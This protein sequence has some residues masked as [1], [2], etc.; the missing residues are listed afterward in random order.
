[1]R[2]RTA[3]IN[4]RVVTARTVIDKGTLLLEEGRIERIFDKPP[5]LPE[6]SVE[7]IDC[8]GKIVMPGFIDLHTHGGIGCDFADGEEILPALSNYYFSHGVTSLLAT[9]SPLP[10]SLLKPAV[11]RIANYC[12]DKKGNTNIYGLH[13]EGPYINKEMC[14][15]NQRDY[16]EAPNIDEWSKVRETGKGLIK[17]MTLAPELPGVL[18][19]IKD[20][21]TNG[22]I[23]S[24]GHSKASGDIMVQMI[25]MG[26]KQVTHLFNSMPQL[27]HREDGILLETL[28][29]EK[30]DAQIIADGIH[31][32][33]KAI[34]MAIRLKT[35]DHILLIT[36]ST[37]ATQVGDGEY[38][39]A[40][41]K[42]VVK[43]GAVRSEDGA[44]AGSTLVME[45]GLAYLSRTVGIDLVEASKMTSLTAARS[46]GIEKV[47]GSVEEGK[48]ADL[49]VLDDEFNVNLTMLGGEIK[50]TS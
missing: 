21:I 23:I 16:V 49:V 37:R 24:I 26:A 6:G 11:E 27:H 33:P 50:Y 34:E 5:E 8:S 48:R 44:L 41:R 1:M 17:L 10:Y 15:G 25:S 36:D 2:R 13:L 7:I 39:S 42:V 38:V 32:H 12:I 9:L 45:K 22:I 43:G 47:T 19:I 40:G 28:L 30:I 3:L 4:G 35:P 46:L 29:S 14:G 31:V 18:P 20:S